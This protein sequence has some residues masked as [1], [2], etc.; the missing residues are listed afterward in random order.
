MA[1]LTSNPNHTNPNPDPNHPNP[2]PN[3]T[4][5][6]NPDPYAL[7]PGGGGAP[8]YHPLHPPFLSSLDP[9]RRRG[10]FPSPLAPTLPILPW[11]QEEEGLL[12]RVGEWRDTLPL[13]GRV[14][15]T[16]RFVPP[17]RGRM[18]V[19]CHVQKHSENGMMAVAAITA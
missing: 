7:T 17:F 18:M 9:R 2:N 12:G 4:P 5:T 13:Y 11:P 19:H 6:P 16:I 3:P 1:T 14:G 15:Y 10:S 8:S